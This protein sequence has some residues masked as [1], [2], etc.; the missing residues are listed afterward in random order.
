MNREKKLEAVLV[1]AIGFLVLF[2]VFKIKIF[3]LISL[4]V[5]L[6]S[7]ISDLCMNG[8]TWIWFKISEILGWINS[9][10]LLGMV[11]F[12]ILLPISLFARLLNKTAIKLKKS[13]DSYYKTRDHSYL[14]EDIENMW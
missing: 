10:I 1:I 8:I 12:I 5:L 14:P 4:L 2:F 13:N 7:V 11:F 3:V 9:R 6:L